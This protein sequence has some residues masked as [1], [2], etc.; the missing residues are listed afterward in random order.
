M[1]RSIINTRSIILTSKFSTIFGE[2]AAPTGLET[3]TAVLTTFYKQS[4]EQVAEILKDGA[5]PAEILSSIEAL[6][7]VRVKTITTT[8]ETNKYQE[9]YKKAKG[10]ERTAVETEVKA[11]YGIESDLK[12]TELFDYIAAEKAKE[13]G[14]TTEDAIKKTP[15]Y[16]A[17]E[18]K[19]KKEVSETKKTY[20]DKIKEME[21]GYKNELSFNEVGANSL[22]ML[23][24]L[25]AV[26]PK[27]AAV[28]ETQRKNFLNELKNG[29]SYERNGNTFLV[30]KDGK[31]LQDEHGH[32][33]SYEDHVKTVAANHFEFAANN[34]GENPGGDA[35][36]QAAAAAASAYPKNVTKPKNEAEYQKIMVDKNIPAAD[37][38]KVA[39]TWKKEN[40]TTA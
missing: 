1:K 17:L 7:K 5:T 27:T 4:K 21:S 2:G 13:S 31:L 25:S 26:I 11:H 10:E 37:R 33:L 9:G 28:A 22:S 23:N 8:A 35:A 34:G 18:S 6:D 36:T 19:Y 14:A 12:G 38:R 24:G 39:D 20:E 3:L 16:Q 29:Y 40:P 32:T 30:S 15:T